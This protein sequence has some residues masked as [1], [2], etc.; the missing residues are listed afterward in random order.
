MA[1]WAAARRIRAHAPSLLLAATAAG[2]AFLVAGLVVGW[3]NAV[4]APVAAV[5]ATGLSAGQR[6]RRAA[7]ISLGVVVGIVAADLLIRLVGLGPL[8]L[9]LAVLLAMTV[10]VAIRPSGLLVNQAAVA[11][12]V[13]M[14]L[15]P[16][17]EASPWVRALDAVIGGAVAVLLNA[18]IAP[19][20]D[21]AARTAAQGL[22]D[23]YA[24]TVRGLADA[25]EKGSVTHAE[26]CLE[27]IAA[28]DRAADDI[29]DALAAT[30]D[31]LRL[32]RRAE[33]A[34]AR[35]A[36]TGVAGRSVIL[37]ATARGLSR[38]SA[39][40]VRHGEASP[41]LSTAL[42]DLAESVE[43]LGSW[44]AGDSTTD[45]VRELALRAAA[46]A[47]GHQPRTQASAMLIG[48]IRSA[49]VDILRTVG[50]GQPQAVAALE[51]AAGRADEL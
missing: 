51:E 50:M 41:H 20:P 33:R 3:A 23:S 26:S 48:Q 4:F 6:I 16:Q 49:V 21:R 37:L 45:Q 46:L 5:V 10:A 35:S 42:G 14:A 12:V 17:L 24:S 8:Q 7:E 39:N 11:A 32:A 47:S 34:R 27:E 9:A 28:L 30:R 15:V 1:E 13:V 31:R 22:L 36:I 18:L 44:V 2:T 38:S 25:V 40:L 19:D 43:I 29:H